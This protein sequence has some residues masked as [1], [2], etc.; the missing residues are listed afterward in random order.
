M[1]P[2]ERAARAVA[3]RALLE[4]QTVKDALASIEAD[5]VTEWKATFDPAER[6]NLWRAINI[7]DRLLSWMVSNASSDLAALKRAK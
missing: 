7:K 1:T 3:L 2:E 5:L 4:D 6:D